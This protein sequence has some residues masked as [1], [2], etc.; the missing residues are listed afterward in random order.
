MNF[1]CYGAICKLLEFIQKI[2]IPSNEGPLNL[3]NLFEFS[4]VQIVHKTNFNI[5]FN[6][7]SKLQRGA[8]QWPGS[9]S[10]I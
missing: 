2:N 8:K 1:V 5:I 4:L 7:I 10:I 3:K 9:S 6:L